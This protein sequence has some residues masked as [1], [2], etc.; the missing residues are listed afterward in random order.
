MAYK[1][2]EL[3]FSFD[4]LE[5]HIDAKTVEIHHDKHHSGY[6]SKL[7]DVVKGKA[8]LE[9]KSIEDLISNLNSIDESIRTKVRNLGGGHYAH[10]L[11]WQVIG[12]KAGGE[13]KGE[14]AEAIKKDFGSFDAFKEKFN[15]AATTQFG[16]GWAW[17]Y[18]SDGKLKV[19]STLNQDSPLMDIS[20]DRGTPILTIDVWEHAYYLNYQNRRPEYITAF[21]NIINWEAGSANYKEVLQAS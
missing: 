11:Y 5:P 3:T 21:W 19:C 20:K 1:V 10:S 6:V 9:S 13:A 14:L 8:E 18:V 12:P 4:A 17:L 2:P 16:S 15:S 7:N